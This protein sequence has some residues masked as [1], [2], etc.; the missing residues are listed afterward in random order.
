[1]PVSLDQSEALN[2]IRLEGEIDIE[3]AA[4]LKQLLL[5]GLTPG[6]E[7]LVDLTNAT[8]L[9]ITSLQLLWAAQRDAVAMGTRLSVA[10]TLPAHLLA[11]AVGAG[12]DTFPG[13]EDQVS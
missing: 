2:T 11:A 10:D 7:L 5:Q 6:K 13:T 9:D 3:C 4:E 1:M 12:F 8:E